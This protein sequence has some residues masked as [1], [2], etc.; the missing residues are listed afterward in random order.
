MAVGE[1]EL[2]ARAKARLGTI[3]R[4]KYRVDRVLGAGG[5]ATVYAAT[6]LRNAN[7]VAVK[8]LHRELTL[9]RDLRERFLREG[10]AANSVEHPGTVR[11]LDDD[12]AEDGALFLV[13]ELLDGETLDARWERKNRRIPVS[14]VVPLISELLDVLDAAHSKGIVHRDLKPENLF[15]TREGRLK[16]LDFGVARLREGTPATQTRTGAVFGTPAFMPPEQALGRSAEVDAVSDIWSV[17][18][19]AFA[20][21]AG[22]HVHGGTTAEEI[23]VQA[24]TR[25]APALNGVAP[26]VPTQIACVIDQALAAEKKDWWPSARAMRE[27]LARAWQGDDAA[28]LGEQ[29][30]VAPPPKTTMHGT[31]TLAMGGEPDAAPVALPTLPI[32]STVAGISASTRGPIRA[33]RRRTVIVGAA[34]ASLLV[35]IAIAVGVST[36][37]RRPEPSTPSITT[38]AHSGVAPSRSAPVQF[39]SSATAASEAIEV[40]GVPV[41]ALP[42]AASA[43]VPSPITTTAAGPKP[44]T[45][46]AASSTLP[47]AM[48]AVTAAKPV[49]PQPARPVSTPNRDPLAP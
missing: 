21:L 43:G 26:D 1:D 39:A 48:P 31:G 3:L 22:R 42:A 10:Y 19:T 45:K 12:S 41:E 44:P 2:L 6:H 40:P 36:G 34:A 29:T 15:V 32:A 5:M 16:V 18:A 7:R 25:P 9:E 35:G 37:A 33:P 24:A 49:P 47:P 11:I 14:E 28:G 23:L 38:A 17:G 20:L 30:Q 13:M 46:A 8:V 4:G 27:A